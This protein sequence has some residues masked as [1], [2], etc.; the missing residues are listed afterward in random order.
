VLINGRP[1]RIGI[2]FGRERE[3]REQFVAKLIVPEDPRK[4]LVAYGPVMRTAIERGRIALGMTR[5]QVLMA[6]GYPRTDLTPSLQAIRWRYVTHQNDEYAIV[7]GE[8]ERVRSVEAWP[9]G[10][11]ALVLHTPE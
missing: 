9:E 2:D 3:T 5:E 11:Q 8:D 4:R 1:M 6:L 7:W 10:V